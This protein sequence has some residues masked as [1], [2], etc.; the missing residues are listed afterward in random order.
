MDSSEYAMIIEVRHAW[1]QGLR[2]EQDAQQRS[3][4]AKKQAIG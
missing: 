1:T 3:D 4:A 2:D